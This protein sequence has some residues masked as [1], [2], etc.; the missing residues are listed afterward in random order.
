MTTVDHGHE[1]VLLAEVLE[2]LDPRPGDVVVDAT[3]GR[4]GHAAALAARA[5]ALGGHPEE[6]AGRFLGFDLDAANLEY[7][8][9]RLGGA[10]DRV[11][12]VH[13]SFDAVADQ[14]AAADRTVDVL[15]ADLGFSSNQMDDP[16]RGFSF[17]ADG[18]LDMRLDRSCGIT[19]AEYVNT[20]SE[21][22]LADVIHR[23]GEDPF[24]RRIAR[25]LAEIRRDR[26]ITTTGR[27]AEG[28]REAY[29]ARARQ[30]RMHPATRTFMALRIAVNDELGAL[31]RLL[32]RIDAAATALKTGDRSEAWLAS[33]ARVGIISF[34][35][36]EDRAVKRSFR[37]LADRGLARR[38]TRKPV[39]PS[40]AEQ[41]RNRRARS[42][43]LRVV[44]ID[45][46][47]D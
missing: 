20:A 25:K 32:D 41:L 21:A 46:S 29:G 42:A 14:A 13:G 17:Q 6:A 39:V 1:P 43:K 7:A 36:L 22:E 23:Y 37:D 30:S 9:S 18:P 31:E 28:V 44:R 47:T 12:L 35:S 3:V 19:A 11:T 16:E 40:E 27:L 5:N 45:D 33:G 15:F 26:P 2:R 38:I 24:A 8:A 34:H 4:G 10:S